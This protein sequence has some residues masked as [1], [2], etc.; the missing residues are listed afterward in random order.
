MRW[1]L[2]LSSILHILIFASFFYKKQAPLEDAIVSVSLNT[3]LP[4]KTAAKPKAA[5]NSDTIKKSKMAKAEDS[6]S[7][8]ETSNSSNR[9][10]NQPAY[11]SGNVSVKPRVLKQVQ[12][13]YPQLAK[14]AR[15]EGAVKLSVIINDDGH[16]RDVKILEGPGYGLNE[17]AEQALKQFLFSPAEVLGQKVPVQIVYVYRFKLESR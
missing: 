2:L 1:W 3:D 8:T 6:P 17:A 11:E 10:E 5:A 16:V 4:P 12:V 13:I 9:E 7:I 14:E 15:I